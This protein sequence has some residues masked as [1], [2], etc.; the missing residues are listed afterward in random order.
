ILVLQTISRVMLGAVTAVDTSGRAVLVGE[1]RIP[2][3]Y[4]ILATG[5]RDAYYGHDEWAAF[6]LN[7]KDIEDAR[8]MRRR[9]LLAFERAEDSDDEAERRQLM[10]FVIVG[11]GPTGVELAGALRRLFPA[12]LA[13]RLPRLDATPTP[14]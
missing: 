3:D 9:I 7:L 4:L 6:T 2:Y 12:S 10:T 13:P 8:A 5:A 14:A 11:G 1:R